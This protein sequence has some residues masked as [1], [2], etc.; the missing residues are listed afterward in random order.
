MGDSALLTTIY[1]NYQG[2]PG[3]KEE[4]V[5]IDSSKISLVSV[6]SNIYKPQNFGADEAILLKM[7]E[8]NSKHSEHVQGSVKNT[9][10]AEFLTIKVDGKKRKA[11][12]I[13]R[14]SEMSRS[15]KKLMSY[16]DYFVNGI[17]Y[18]K[19]TSD[20]ITIEMLKEQK[21]DPNPPAL[22]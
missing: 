14:S 9:Y 20:D 16:S 19:R 17:G 18:Y 11:I 3:W 15:G 8:E 2:K 1:P 21:Y 5:K 13:T 22:K 7:P 10:M 4:I 12:K 6:N